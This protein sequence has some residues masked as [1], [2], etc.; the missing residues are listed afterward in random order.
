MVTAQ[1]QFRVAPD[2]LNAMEVRGACAAELIQTVPVRARVTGT[3]TW[4]V[5]VHVFELISCGKT[6]TGY[7]W[8]VDDRVFTAL[9]IGPIRSPTDAVCAALADEAR[10][11]KLALAGWAVA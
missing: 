4:D 3:Q 1:P 2:L 11:R 10:Q 9:D 6:D 8:R 7:A 5:D